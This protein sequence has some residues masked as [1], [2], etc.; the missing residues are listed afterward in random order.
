MKPIQLL[1]ILFILTGSAFAQ[2]IGFAGTICDVKTKAPLDFVKVGIYKNGMPKIVALT[3]GDGY[4]SFKNFAAGAY[5]LKVEGNRYYTLD[6]LI[7]IEKEVKIHFELKPI[8]D[9]LF[10]SEPSLVATRIS[11]E[12]ARKE[13]AS[14]HAKLYLTADKSVLKQAGDDDFQTKYSIGYINLGSQCSS[15]KQATEYN[16]VVF[17]HLD[18]EYGKEWRKEARKDVLGLTIYL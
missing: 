2:S 8:P 10:I 14:G 3:E 12:R 16:K 13:I 9:S 18:K 1:L 11:A 17:R 15:I 5:Q 7:T 4:F 6:T